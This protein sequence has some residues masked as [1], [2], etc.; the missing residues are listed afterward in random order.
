M[1]NSIQC[2]VLVIGGGAAA[3]R[4]AIEA[5]DLGAHVLMVAKMKYGYSGSSFYD[6]SIPWGMMMAGEGK[7]AESAFLEEV[8]KAS[9][10]CLN[11]KLTEIL[12]RDSNDRLKDLMN[13]GIELRMNDEAPCFGK[14]PRGAMLVNM[15]NARRSFKKQIEKRNIS[16]IEDLPIHELVV[17]DR[18][19]HGALGTDPFGNVV[20][21][22]S[23]TV[24][25]AT[26]GA[27]TLWEYG[28]AL[29]DMTGDA[30]AMA[31]R[32]GARLANLEFIQFIPGVVSPL[33]RTNFHHPTLRSFPGVYNSSGEECLKKYLPEGI[34]AEMC[35]EA[36]AGHGPFSCE[37]D[38]KYFDI[39]LCMEE[40]ASSSGMV[41]GAEIRYTDAFFDDSRY[42]TWRGF[43]ATRGIDA[44]KDTLRIY[45]HCQGF[46]G[47]VLID[48]HCAT[49][50][51]NLYACGECAG[52]PHGANRIGGNAILGTQVFGRIAGEQAALKSRKMSNV[53]P[54]SLND[55]KKQAAASFDT[56]YSSKHRPKE[57]MAYIRAVMQESAFIIRE[58]KKMAEGIEKLNEL[59][60]EYNACQFVNDGGDAAEALNA[61]N[62][63][64]TSRL[65]LFSMLCRRESRGGHYRKDFPEKDDTLFGG[66]SI[67]RVDDGRNIVVEQNRHLQD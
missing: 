65:I 3:T 40:A 55:L 10:G 39:A 51:E 8:L 25:L 57:V 56:G 31:A 49:D 54:D 29:K 48:E 43:L 62:S 52:G 23:K 17:R 30:Y 47:G 58:E 33:N 35:L 22:H 36:R 18:I 59:G 26:G 50:I 12:V 7:E 9:C 41:A 34:T 21:I 53:I 19:C 66:M 1:L 28:F 13:Y 15:D 6:N 60:K 63:L 16:V 42:D 61:S 20:M 44:K 14:K 5:S 11:R 37:D 64:M 27:E 46:N 45:P 24:I 67:A 38:S 4:A 32:N 2:D